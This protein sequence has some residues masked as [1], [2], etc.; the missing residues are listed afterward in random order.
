MIG[1][2]FCIYG[3]DLDP[4]AI[5]RELV[6]N[7]SE[8]FRRGSPIV[9]RR[10]TYGDHPT[11]GWLLRTQDAVRSTDLEVHLA[12]LLSQLRPQTGVIRKLAAEGLDIA[13]ICLISGGP[14][15]GGPTISA[16]TLADITRL[17]IPVDL[18]VY[19]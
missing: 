8:S 4:E 3:D 19:C 11:G 2:I 9:T 10:R 6:I 5:T 17:G 14:G 1:A 16:N 18:D 13:L 7:P 15:G 12:W